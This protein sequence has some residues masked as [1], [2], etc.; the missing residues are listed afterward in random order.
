MGVVGL[1]VLWRGMRAEALL[2]TLM[3]A[4][5]FFFAMNYVLVGY[6]YFIPTYLVFGIWIAA[7]LAWLGKS[8]GAAVGRLGGAGA[9]NTLR[10]S[11]SIIETLSDA[12][13]AT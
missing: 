11:T 6:L 9:A 1:G 7:G 13:F 10:L 4:G 5:N 12:W 2:L 8:I 3:V